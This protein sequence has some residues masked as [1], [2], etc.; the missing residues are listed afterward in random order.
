LSLFPKKSEL[1]FGRVRHLFCIRENVFGKSTFG[2]ICR[3]LQIGTGQIFVALGWVSH[4][5][6]G[7]GKF[8]NM[9][10]RPVPVCHAGLP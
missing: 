7:F 5:Q 10:F 3:A 2:K 6:F 9:M 8:G 4:L 1:I